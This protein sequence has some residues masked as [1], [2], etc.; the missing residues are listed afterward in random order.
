M[1][2]KVFHKLVS[3]DEA[4][5]LTINRV[6]L[7]PIG[8][9]EVE[10]EQAL[11]RVLA[12][13]IYAPIDHPPFDR[14]EVD[15]YAVRSIDVSYATELNPVV[16]KVVGYLKTGERGEELSCSEGAI[17]VST[18]AIIPREC[19]AVVMEE[20]AEKTNDFLR[21]YRPVAPG[22]NVVT[23]GSDVS[24]GDFMLPRGLLIRH[25][26]IALLAGLGFSKI[27]VYK[28]PRVAVYST[29]YEVLKPGTKIEPGK[30][31]DVNGYLISSFL[32]ELGAESIYR[33]ILPDDYTNI[34][35]TIEKDL[36]VFDAVFTSGGTSVGEHDIVYRV[37]EDMGEVIVHGLKSKPGRPTV[38]ATIRDKIVIGLPGFPLSCYMVLVRVVK[39]II[40]RMTGLNY[41][42]KKVFVKLPFK[43]RKG[44]GKTWLIPSILVETKNGYTAYPVSMSSGSIYAITYSDGFIELG[45]DIDVVE[46]GTLVPF[47]AFN[48]EIT[49][50]KL[51]II[52]SNDPLL[53][54]LLVKSRLI[55]Y[56]RVLNTG[57]TSGW[58]AISRGEADIAPTHLL[59]PSTGLYNTPFLDKFGLREKVV[60]IRGYDRLIGLI[61]AKGNP[62][63]ISCFEDFFRE[64]IRI[65]NRPQGSGIRVLLDI[66]LKKIAE[67]RGISWTNIP[68]IIK[69]YTYEVKTHTAV[70]SAVKNGKADVGVATGYVAKIHGLDFIPITWEEYDFLVP[71]DR[72][73]KPELEVFLSNLMQLT[74]EREDFEFR[75][76]YRVPKNIGLV[77]EA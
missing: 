18:G 9:E 69:G 48:E 39:P 70:A 76:Y 45:E 58:I 32:T 61:V 20:Y 56:S 71:K 37:L 57:S 53:E 43:V 25:E 35:E 12:S 47:Y 1:S 44:V 23:A 7:A 6:K 34:R 31:Y 17:R 51:T 29:G 38:I 8:V 15:G 10:V 42:E 2:V 72:L 3:L 41:L 30:V 60:I 26:H 46:S 55:Y 24:S 77:K 54:H 11:H 22:E 52:G 5:E 62:K 74:L 49:I 64:D 16:L 19:D 59:D 67:K 75:N 68:R 65:V 13:D 36:E 4:I 66:Y 63:N 28:K 73:K 14:A 50:R 40:T 21:V 33:G 27:P